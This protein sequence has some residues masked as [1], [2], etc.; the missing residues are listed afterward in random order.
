MRREIPILFDKKENCCG[1]TACYAICPRTAI[2]M[3][4]DEEGFLYPSINDSI[5]IDCG[6]CIKVCPVKAKRAL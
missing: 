1:C 4:E 2:K 3:I 6:Q 5:C